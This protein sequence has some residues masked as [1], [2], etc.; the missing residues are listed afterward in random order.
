MR[1]IGLSSCMDQI[2][3][4]LKYPSEAATIKIENSVRRQE[5]EKKKKAKHST[6]W[7]VKGTIRTGGRMNFLE[8]YS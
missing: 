8:L 4:F 7:K 2:T 3:V 1:E 6:V 5:V